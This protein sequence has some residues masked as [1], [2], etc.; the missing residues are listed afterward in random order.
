MD[1]RKIIAMGADHRGFKLKETLKALLEAKGYGVRDFGTHD[2]ESCDYP[3]YG[4]PAARAVAKGQASQGVLMCATGNGMAI[5]ANK[6]K[7]IRA[8]LC[9][10]PAM[11]RLARA[12]NDA[13]VLVLPADFVSQEAAKQ[14]LETW[15]LTRFERGRHERRVKKFMK[16]E[17]RGRS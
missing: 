15:L 2:T 1:K 13:N 9:L 8:A 12:H 5:S 3:D 16:L 17:G 11:A 14:I 10:N 4:I 6:V 7:G